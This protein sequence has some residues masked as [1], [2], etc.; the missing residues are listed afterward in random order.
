MITPR[1]GWYEELPAHQRQNLWRYLQS[2]E[3]EGSQVS[4]ELMRLAWSS[5]AA[6]SVAPLQD[7]LNLGPE[8]R[9]N[10]PGRAEGN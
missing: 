7:L 9:I 4:R 5:A 8:A 1:A 10:V 3:R 6:L 2:P